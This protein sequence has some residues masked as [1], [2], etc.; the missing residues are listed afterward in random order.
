[1]KKVL[2]VAL[3][4]L[5]LLAFSQVKA[6]KTVK[7]GYVDSEALFNMMPEKDSIQKTLEEFYA[8]LQKQAGAMNQELQTKLADYQKNEAGMSDIIKETKQRE[9]TDLQGRI[10]EFSNL[11]QQRL[12]EKQAEITQPVITKIKNAVKDVAKEHGYNYIFNHSEN[13]IQNI[14]Y[15]EPADDVMPLVKAKLGLK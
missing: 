13:N 2:S 7:L 3:C 6:Q 4:M 5:C 10:D 14:L 15:A 1:M 12:S 9:I 11:A 8:T